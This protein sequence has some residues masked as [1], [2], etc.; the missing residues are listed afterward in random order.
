MYDTF[1]P[2]RE[3]SLL[4]SVRKWQLVKIIISSVFNCI[5][6]I[7]LRTIIIIIHDIS[8]ACTFSSQS[9][10]CCSTVTNY[11]LPSFWTNQSRND[12]SQLCGQFELIYTLSV[13][14]LNK[15]HSAGCQQSPLQID[16]TQMLLV[17]ILKFAKLVK[18]L[19]K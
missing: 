15:T 13:R 9:L 2:W 16:T 10:F 7:F 3:I 12:N 8:C 11:Y 17:P 18:I 4:H 5:S 6:S 1:I 19:F 14:G